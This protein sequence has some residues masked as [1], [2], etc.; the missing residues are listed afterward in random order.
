M[1]LYSDHRSLIVHVTLF[2]LLPEDSVTVFDGVEVALQ[3]R[4]VEDNAQRI[5]S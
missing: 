4:F 1:T 5:A 3:F 2:L